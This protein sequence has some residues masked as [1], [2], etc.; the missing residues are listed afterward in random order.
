MYKTEWLDR[1]DHEALTDALGE[2][3]S[4]ISE[5]CYHAGWVK[6]TV[7]LVPALRQRVLKIHSPQPWA[8]GEL[9]HGMAAILQT[10]ADKLGHWA[11][12]DDEGVGHVPFDPFPTPQAH[13][14]DLD[15]W[16]QKQK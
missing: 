1:V 16:R 2:L 5:D 11:N 8:H 10:I 13:L 15:H 12:L 6:G 9:G 3:M 14:D 7:Y 4:A